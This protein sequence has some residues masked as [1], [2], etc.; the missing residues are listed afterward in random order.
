MKKPKNQPKVLEIS[1]LQKHKV[2]ITKEPD[3]L[4]KIYSSDGR[5]ET[6]I[7]GYTIH[8]RNDLI[9]TTIGSPLVSMG[10]LKALRKEIRRIIRNENK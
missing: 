1:K 7:P 5:N 6:C 4:V 10:D 8:F 2:Y 3:D 9:S